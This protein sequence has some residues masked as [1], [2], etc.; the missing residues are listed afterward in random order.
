[1]N[2]K[3]YIQPNSSENKICGVHGDAIK[4]KIKAPPVDG[5]ANKEII[6]FLSDYLSLSKSHI[7]IKHGDT[8]RNKLVHLNIS[9]DLEPIIW[10]KL[11]KGS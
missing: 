1:M 4:L 9:K 7:E 11:K 3:F 8:G 5:K 2:I 10:E 6:E